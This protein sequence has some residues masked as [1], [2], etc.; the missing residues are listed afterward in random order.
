[1]KTCKNCG[2]L[3]SSYFRDEN[4]KIHNLNNRKYCFSCSPFKKH[5]TQ[6]LDGKRKNLN[7]IV[8]GKQ[9]TGN[10]SKYCSKHCKSKSLSK[11]HSQNSSQR[12]SIKRREN[13]IRAISNLGERC[14][15]C[16]YTGSPEAFDFH[17]KN[18]ELKQYLISS[19]LHYSWKNLKNELDKCILLCANCHLIIHYKTKDITKSQRHKD[20]YRRMAVNYLG[21]KCVSCGFE[22]NINALV[23]HHKEPE[24]KDFGIADKLNKYSWKR[25]QA[26]LDKC[27]LMCEICHRSIEFKG[28]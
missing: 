18:K 1:M 5:N 13:K 21:S 2:N 20:K 7:C 11:I 8:C 14:N 9:L 4:G 17:H 6:V 26:E 15:I 3:F 22:D 25:I 16:G 19:I 27:I 28:A 12:I 24:S 10:Q 23:F